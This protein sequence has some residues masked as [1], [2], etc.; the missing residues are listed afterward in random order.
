M[1]VLEAGRGCVPGGVEPLR[2]RVYPHD[3]A[4]VTV[5]AAFPLDLHKLERT[6]PGMS[7]AQGQQGFLITQKGHQVV[8]RETTPQL[9][10]MSDEA[11]RS[12]TELL[13]RRPRYAVA[14]S[15]DDVGDYRYEWD[16]VVEFAKAV[17]Q[18]V[19]LAVLHDQAGTTYLIN[20][21]R[22]LVSHEEY[23]ALRRPGTTDFL[24]R[25]LGW[26]R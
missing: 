18:R 11:I 19:P 1:P 14:C 25:M 16:I 12:A 20:P 15:F 3:V 7:P 13:G 21:K 6:L 5:L 9:A 4:V 8:V 10:Q 26:D 17:A 22:G 2:K 24:R 23:E